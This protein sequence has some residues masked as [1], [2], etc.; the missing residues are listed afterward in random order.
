MGS[1]I[2]SIKQD[3]FRTK[4][5]YASENTIYSDKELTSELITEILEKDIHYIIIEDPSKI[6]V[7][8]FEKLNQEIFK[9]KPSITLKFWVIAC[10]EEINIDKIKCLTYLEDILFTR[11]TLKNYEAF[12]SLRK[13]KKFSI[14][15]DE[16]LDLKFIDYLNEDLESFTLLS[17]NTKSFKHSLLGLVR[18]KKLKYLFIQ[19]NY[20]KTD[21]IVIQLPEIDTLIISKNRSIKDFNFLTQLK[22]LKILHLKS[23]SIPNPEILKELTNLRFLELY[24]IS[25]V[26]NLNFLIEMSSLEHLFLQ[27]MNDISCFPKLSINSKLRKIELWYMK[28][29]RNFKSLENL[30]SLREFSCREMKENEPNDFVPVLLNHTIERI[31]IW[32]LKDGQRKEMDNLYSIHNKCY[33]SVSFMYENGS[34]LD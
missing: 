25:T 33:S 28:S 13:L 8:T 9:K 10:H 15:I 30:H 3:F 26:S 32:F 19:G 18:F 1:Y 11:F 6:S 27:T 34:Y 31:E 23:V 29:L 7:K 5:K 12:V 17:E 14:E 21:E 2:H 24:K 22:N 16:D 20:K 4:H